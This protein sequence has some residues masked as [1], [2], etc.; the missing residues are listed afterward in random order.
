MVNR[1]S[2]RK[3]VEELYHDTVHRKGVIQKGHLSAAESSWYKFFREAIGNVSGLTV[4]EVGCG[5]GW[6]SIRLA[7]AGAKVYGIDISGELVKTAIAEAETQGC[8]E[9][10]FFAKMA[11]ED[12]SFEDT[13][14]DLVIGS[15]IL[16]HTEIGSSV[17]N[18]ER[19]LKQNGRAVFVEP[20]NENPVLKMW[21]RLTPWRRS[22]TEKALLKVDLEFIRTV[23]HRAAYHYFGFTSMATAGL[24]MLLPNNSILISINRM[25]ERIDAKIAQSFPY[26]GRYYAV[27]VLELTSNDQVSQ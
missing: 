9:N 8:S 13:Y 2:D 21:R 3:V 6:L 14:F 27:V 4:L 15:A 5:S 22:P 10:T 25:L 12:L 1:F 20:M 24:L 11:V 23:F 26:L 17:T 18:I 16:H 7:K 19:V